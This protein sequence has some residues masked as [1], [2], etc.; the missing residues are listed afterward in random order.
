MEDTGHNNGANGNCVASA[1]ICTP[2][3]KKYIRCDQVNA[4]RYAADELGKLRLLVFARHA[5]VRESALQVGLRDL[6]MELSVAGVV[7]SVQVVQRL[8]A[9]DVLLFVVQR[10]HQQSRMLES[11]WSCPT[12]LINS[13]M[14]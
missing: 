6:P 10:P 8:Y 12:S 5:Q 4:V 7:D 2:G 11:F 9:S 13:K 3:Q 14:P 1:T